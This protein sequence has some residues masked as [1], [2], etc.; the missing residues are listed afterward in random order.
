VAA[1]R[2]SETLC[3]AILGDCQLPNITDQAILFPK[4]KKLVLEQFDASE[5]SLQTLIAGCL[6]LECLLIAHG[7]GF[8]CVRI[9]S[10]SLRSICVQG[11]DRFRELIIEN[12]PCLERFR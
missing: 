6:A 7:Y 2:F 10:I 3:V 9:N 11:R 1:F 12:A 8:R 5:S 4:L